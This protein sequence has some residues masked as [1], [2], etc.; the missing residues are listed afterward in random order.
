MTRGWSESTRI[1]TEGAVER[2]NHETNERHENEADKNPQV[3]A[4]MG[5]PN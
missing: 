3:K 5:E 2:G 1:M 4:H